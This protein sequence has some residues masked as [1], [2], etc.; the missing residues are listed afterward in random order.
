M[1]FPAQGPNRSPRPHTEHRTDPWLGLTPTLQQS[2]QSTTHGSITKT[3]SAIARR[4]LVESAWHYTR[5]PIEGLEFEMDV[6][7]VRT[8]RVL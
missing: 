4:L 1:S 3:G 6:R 8:E 2:G 5:P 7:G